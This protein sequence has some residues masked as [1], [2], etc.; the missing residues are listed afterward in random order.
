LPAGNALPLEKAGI[1][2]HR[3]EPVIQERVRAGL[4]RAKAEGKTLCRTKIAEKLNALC[5]RP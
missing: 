2:C 4:A 1:S 3:F 5:G